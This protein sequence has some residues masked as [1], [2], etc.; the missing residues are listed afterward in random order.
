MSKLSYVKG[1]HILLKCP[2]R[3]LLGKPAMAG[4]SFLSLSCIFHATTQAHLFFHFGSKYT[5]IV[6]LALLLTLRGK[7]L[8]SNLSVSA[9]PAPASRY[10]WIELKI[11]AARKY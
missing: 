3:I 11:A 10:V 9:L 8:H 1:F 7:E 2:L 5:A 4:S 6:L